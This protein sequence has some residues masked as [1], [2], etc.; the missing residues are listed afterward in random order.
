MP[1]FEEFSV[2][3]EA[4]FDTWSPRVKKSTAFIVAAKTLLKAA[5]EL[6]NS[7]VFKSFLQWCKDYVLHVKDY[8][9]SDLE[10]IGNSVRMANLNM[11]YLAS[12]ANLNTL[13][14]ASLYNGRLFP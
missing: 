14:V 6:I 3:A 7:D 1:S 10:K 2:Q 4:F 8:L 12:L 13:C 5:N 11:L 9:T